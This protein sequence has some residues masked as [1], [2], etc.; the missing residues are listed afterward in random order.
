MR[1]FYFDLLIL[2]W[3]LLFISNSHEL[4]QDQSQGLLELRMFL[5]YPSSLQIMEN[6]NVDFC[7]LPSSSN[8]SI[9]CED[10]SIVELKIFGDKSLKPSSSFNGFAIPN[11]TLS[12]NF[13]IDSFFITLTKLKTLKVL[14]LVSLGIWGELPN[15]IESLSLLQVLDLSSNFLFGSIPPKISTMVNLQSL[16][17]DENDFNNT[18]PNW[19][20]SLFNLTFL[21]LKKNHFK[22]SFPFSLCK[23]KKLEVISLSQNELSGELPSFNSLSGLHVLDLRE[24]R[25]EF[26]LP[27]LPKSVVTVL[28]SNNWFSGEIPK[29]FGA[30]NH[31][32]HLD[33]S[34]NRLEGTPPS[35]LFSLSNL[36]YLSLAN[37]LLSGEFP[38]KLDCGGKLG[39]VDISSNKLSGLLPSCLANSSDGRVVRYGRNCLSVEAQNQQRGSYCKDFGSRWKKFKVLKVVAVVAIVVG[40]V[41]VVLVFGVLV[42]KKRHLMKKSRKEVLVK[43][44]HDKSATGV[45]SEVLANASKYISYLSISVFSVGF[46]L[47][48][49]LSQ[50]FFFFCKR[51]VWIDLFELIYLYKRENV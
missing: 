47:W 3:L 36:S 12:M 15:K 33:L 9:K 22:G 50:S 21:S 25:F 29:K 19:F 44:V 16:T 46:K 35:T 37:N 24:N 8:L 26:E 45:S 13:S 49:R 1:Y 34:S 39:Y 5:E 28:F 43:T 18:L 17:L 41:L 2:T 11:Q 27:L 31:L 40:F 48:L 30:L 10:N 51:A 7:Y 38:D 42:C 20:D 4:E 6:Y 23:I 14:T 32:Q